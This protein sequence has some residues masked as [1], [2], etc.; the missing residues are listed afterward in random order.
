MFAGGKIAP[1][2]NKYQLKFLTFHSKNNLYMSKQTKFNSLTQPR[3]KNCS[4]R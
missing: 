3:H 1:I 2:H 4:N